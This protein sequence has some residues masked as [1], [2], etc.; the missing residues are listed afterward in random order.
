[1]EFRIGD[2]VRIANQVEVAVG[3]PDE[4]EDLLNFTGK[5]INSEPSERN[6][7]IVYRVAFDA[8]TD[9]LYDVECLE[10]E[11]DHDRLVM[12]SELNFDGDEDIEY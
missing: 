12:I 5:I 10:L 8:Y 1:M 11:T 4:M 3:W 6:G 2:I 9:W 7:E